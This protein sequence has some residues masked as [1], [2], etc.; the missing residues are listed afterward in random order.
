MVHGFQ[1]IWDKNSTKEDWGFL[2]VDAN[3]LKPVDRAV[4]SLLKS[5]TH[6]FTLTRHGS[7]CSCDF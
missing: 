3:K 4:D 1:S 6:M 2:L 7:L 5:G